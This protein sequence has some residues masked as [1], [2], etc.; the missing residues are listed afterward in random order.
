MVA[1]DEN[2][3]IHDDS[4]L[5]TKRAN[6]NIFFLLLF[7]GGSI[8]ISLIY[9]PLLLDAL[10]SFEYAVWLTLTSIVGWLVVT[11]IG[12]GN[13][14][15]NKLAESLAQNDTIRGKKYVSTAYC[16]LTLILLGI[17]LIF[18]VISQF[19]N[20]Q[21][22][23][24]S[25]NIDRYELNLLVN[26]VVVS[27]CVQFNLSLINSVLLAIQ[28]PAISSAIGFIGQLLSFAIVY[29]LVEFLKLTSLLP[30][31]VAISVSPIIVYSV[32]SIIF[33]LRNRKIAHF[34]TFY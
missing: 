12:L 34:F 3:E 5:R 27:F 2:K 14:L 8:L 23:L 10:D 25:Y 11:D 9:V 13:G 33:Y 7:K 19:I 24:N 28:M 20:W 31:G 30:I 4:R 21:S 15:R 6:K 16:F 32:A 1:Q 22:V 26:I 29:F 17:I 18:L